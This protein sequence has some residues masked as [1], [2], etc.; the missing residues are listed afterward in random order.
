MYAQPVPTPKEEVFG[1]IENLRYLAALK[2]TLDNNQTATLTKVQNFDAQ[3]HALE[4]QI[5]TLRQTFRAMPSLGFTDQFLDICC[6][7]ASIYMS[8]CFRN[9]DH[10][11]S[12]L[13]ALKHDIIAAIENVEVLYGELKAIPDSETP[14]AEILLW[15]FFVGGSLALE[16]SETTWF[17]SRVVEVLPWTPVANWLEAEACFQRMLWVDK[18]LNPACAALW[19]EVQERCSLSS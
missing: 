12:A 4:E 10:E 18:M 19:A 14:Y 6:I 3:R 2:T 1:L 5:L 8:V 15:A 11:Y 9:F 17:A 13:C 7:A 16:P